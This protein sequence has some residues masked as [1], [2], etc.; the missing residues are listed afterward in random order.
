MGST[1][2]QGA[3]CGDMPNHLIKKA[4]ANKK[5]TKKEA[6]ELIKCAS[7]PFYF[8]NKYLKIQHPTRGEVLFNLYP[9]QE[10]NLK[11][12]V[13]NDKIIILQPRQSGKS[14]LIV[15]YLLWETIFTP[16]V[17]VGI[18]SHVGDSAKD[19]MSRVRYSYESLPHWL[20]PG[21]KSYNVFS[22]EFDNNSSIESTTTTENT[23]R[24]RSK[25]I[26]YLD[27]LAFVNPLI[28]NKFWTSLRPSLTASSSGGRSVKLIVTS[29]PNGSEGLFATLW[30]NSEQGLN[31]FYPRRVYNNEVPGRENESEFKKEM[32]MDMTETQYSQEFECKFLSDSGTLIY[33]P[34]LEALR[35]S[36][37]ISEYNGMKIYRP[38]ENKRLG[39]SVDVG[40][41]TGQDFSVFQVF[42]LDRLEQVAEFRN[43]QLNITDLTKRLISVLKYLNDLAQEVTFTVEANSIGQGVTQLIRNA[44][45]RIFSEIEMISTGKHD[46]ILTTTKSKMKGCTKFKD[47]IESDRMKIHSK[48][49][50]SELKFFVKSGVSFKAERG[51]T[52]D[53][54]MGCVLMCLM[55]DEI[56]LYDAHVYDVLHSVNIIGDMEEEDGNPLPFCF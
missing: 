45:N 37:P 46:G 50:I 29:T 38:L 10:E 24:G 26:L 23:F 51:K 31:D 30:F 9:Y 41:G 55:L 8:F 52:D 49:L 54:V 11:A 15:G 6:Q 42:D 17:N 39:L 47:L 34:I 28:S 56:S 13:E 32:L 40:T 7:D 48:E 36:E 44:D 22:V 25:T 21:V 43:N 19:L 16:D 12:I 18:A 1:K 53:L 20:K 5:L 3:M 33:S 4:Y 27:E 2:Q 14:A 35:P